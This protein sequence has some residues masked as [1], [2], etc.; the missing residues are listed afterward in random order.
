MAA[1]TRG[2]CS[3]NSWDLWSAVIDPHLARFPPRS[4]SHADLTWQYSFYRPRHWLQT[5]GRDV[6][7]VQNPESWAMGDRGAA[8]IKSIERML[9]RGWDVPDF[10][11]LFNIADGPQLVPGSEM[12][13]PMGTLCG[14]AG[15]PDLPIPDMG[16]FYWHD[17]SSEMHGMMYPESLAAALA[18]GAARPYAARTRAAFFRGS[19]NSKERA[20]AVELADAH[21]DV[22]DFYCGYGARVAP[23]LNASNYAVVANMKGNG[24]TA[25]SR[26]VMAM[27]A[28]MLFVEPAD[29]PPQL[30]FF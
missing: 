14:V 9:A 27:G 8:V 2:E 25:R 7:L 13:A 26:W 22:L 24:Y 12:R 1:A 16:F 20:E 29:P 3:T 18:A 28:P 11:L 10:N 21:P 4:V 30:E 5:R 6:F 19:C 17:L 23:L 15:V